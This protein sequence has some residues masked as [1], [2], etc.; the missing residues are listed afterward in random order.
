[1]LGRLQMTTTEAL[2][3]YQLISERVF[4]AKNKKWKVQGG[5]FKATTLETEIQR[6]VGNKLN[7][8]GKDHMFHS[9]TEDGKCAA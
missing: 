1:M 5:A 2:E 6:V 4:G 7:S 8:G 3:E 9:T